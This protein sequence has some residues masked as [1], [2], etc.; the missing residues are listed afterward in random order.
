MSGADKA[1][2]KLEEDIDFDGEG[3]AELCS[4]AP[5]RQRLGA[6]PGGS[7]T[8]GNDQDKMVKCKCH[9]KEHPAKDIPRRRVG[10]CPK[11]RR[12]VESMDTSAKLQSKKTGS[13]E[14]VKAWTVI[15]GND[16]LLVK[17]IQAY[18]EKFPDSQ[19]GK[20]RGHFDFV[21]FQEEHFKS[22]ST[23]SD[24]VDRRMTL[25]QWTVYCASIDGGF[26]QKR[27]FPQRTLNTR[28]RTC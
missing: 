17:A 24:S 2:V 8:A 3:V 13:D 16:E 27:V 25:R 9:N 1:P 7:P 21:Q 10:L 5:K 19:P 6:T 22:H 23:L 14:H 20:F 4:P 18:E 15:K 28:M 11:G 12:V 26:E